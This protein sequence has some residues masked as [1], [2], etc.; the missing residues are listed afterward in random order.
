MLVVAAVVTR[1]SVTYV[2]ADTE[3][4]VQGFVKG[5]AEEEE[6]IYPSKFSLS[7]SAMIRATSHTVTGGGSPF[8]TKKFNGSCE[9]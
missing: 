2:P 8:I 5:S 1:H 7:S 9:I 4:R 6:Y 3:S